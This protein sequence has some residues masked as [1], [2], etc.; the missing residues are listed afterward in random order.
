[1]MARFTLLLVLPLLAGC[2]STDPYLRAGVWRPSQANE[3]NLRAMIV[4]PGELVEA[5]PSNL[6]DGG[7]AAAAAA[8]LR[9]DTVRQLPDSGLAQIK[10]VGSQTPAM[11]QPASAPASGSAP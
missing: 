1:M 2:D 7:L 10:I 3:V 11:A 9:N 8:H 5:H 4:R 6:A